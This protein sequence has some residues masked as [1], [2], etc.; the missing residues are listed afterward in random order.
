[1]PQVYHRS[2]LAG[3]REF[4]SS[5][6]CYI[7]PGRHLCL[8]Q[9]LGGFPNRVRL[10][11]AFAGLLLVL[12]LLSDADFLTLGLVLYQYENREIF[13]AYGI[14]LKS[15]VFLQNLVCVLLDNFDRLP[16]VTD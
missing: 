7:A 2:Y 5:I 9:Q 8:V 6:F 16:Y 4:P 12:Q 13:P 14:S 1:M 10:S 3:Y 11:L 15:L